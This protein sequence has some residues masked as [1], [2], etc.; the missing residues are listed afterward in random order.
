MAHMQ[1]LQSQPS[2]RATAGLLS[3]VL[4]VGLVMLVLW[5]G[6]RGD[7]L[8]DIRAPEPQP[9]SL[10]AVADHGEDD[11]HAL[12]APSA[13]GV[14]PP[15]PP[16]L[17]EPVPP[18]VPLPELD[19]S[20]SLVAEAPEAEGD[21]ADKP[22][23]DAATFADAAEASVPDDGSTLLMPRLQAE[24]LLSRI[25][26]L[27]GQ[28]VT[29]PSARVTWE[30]DGRLFS[31]ELVL[32]P[33]SD[34]VQPERAIAEVSAEEQ[35]RQLR[36]WI[37]LRRLPFSHFAKV[38][39]RW[40]PMVQLH[41]DEVAGRM[42]V[43]SRFNVMY[44]AAASPRLLGKVT[45]AAGGFTV[46]RSGRR[47]DE[48][49][50]A[51][52]IETGTQ[53]IPFSGQ[54]WSFQA[55]G[56]ETNA[57]V[58]EL[59]D[60]TWIRFLAEEGYAWREGRSGVWQHAGPPDGQP[61]HFVAAG[62]AVVHLRGIVSGRFLVHSARR[63][64]VEGNLT[65]ARDPRVDPGS[66]DMLG[67]VSGRDIEV[68]PPSVTGPGDLHIQAAL[69]ARRRI[70]VTQ[71]EHRG[72]ATLHIYGS[73]AAGTLSESEP[74]YATRVE[75]DGRFERSRPPGFPSTNRFAAEDWDRQWTELPGVAEEQSL[76]GR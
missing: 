12:P 29:S 1:R 30:Q 47:R 51:Q 10:D 20:P 41:D 21:A 63:I 32:E 49:V 76:A 39:D 37:R 68:A 45:T 13:G 74:R 24:E 54:G 36:T 65:Y 14:V 44:D 22:E 11:R 17:H 31:A 52:G 71:T 34:G 50:F 7:G 43:N 70:V 33:S 72:F 15:E 61:V 6:G 69:F 35:G 4:H 27:A 38:I 56:P 67:L 23:P 75:F 40:D 42:H 48:D 60:E 3:V 16:V 57:R 5:S 8:H 64:V 2:A 26:R 55:W 25:E 18:S 62:S 66:E 73:L 58:H 19:I 9:V 28:W 53:P 46:I 59:E